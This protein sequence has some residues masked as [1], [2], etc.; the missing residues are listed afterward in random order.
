MG[1][2][3]ARESLVRSGPREIAQGIRHE[4]CAHL[5]G[6]FLLHP[7]SGAIE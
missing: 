5:L 4:Q 2:V 3:T 7:M 1:G 6:L